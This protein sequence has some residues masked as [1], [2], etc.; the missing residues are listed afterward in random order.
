[1]ARYH[2][3]SVPKPS[4]MDYMSLPRE[5]RVRVSKLAAILRACDALSRGQI[6]NAQSLR[7]ERQG[8]ELIIVVPGVN[9]LVLERKAIASKG[10][11]FE[12]IYGMRIRLEEA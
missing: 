11:M 7:L 8:D 4:H 9:N 2:R 3:R 1:M 12:D 5:Q 10:D 6:R